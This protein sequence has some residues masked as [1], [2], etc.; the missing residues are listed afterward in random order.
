M[1][2][3]NIIKFKEDIL[4]LQVRELSDKLLLD[5]LVKLNETITQLFKMIKY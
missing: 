4:D 3:E 5:E 1:K 2:I